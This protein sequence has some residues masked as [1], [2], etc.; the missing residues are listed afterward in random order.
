MK[1]KAD[2]EQAAYLVLKGLAFFAGC[3][4]DALKAILLT[5]DGR[6]FAAGK[7]ILMDQ[8]IGK[9]LFILASGSVG[10]FKR[11]GGE[12]KQLATLKGPDVFGERTMFEESPASALVKSIDKCTVYALEKAHFDTIAAQFPV[13]LEVVKKNMEELRQKRIT[14]SAAPKD[15]QD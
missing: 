15:T 13:I 14:P 10:V 6:E 8:E 7:V 1:L 11:F 4:E 9:T 2:Q 12:K 3:P 5:L